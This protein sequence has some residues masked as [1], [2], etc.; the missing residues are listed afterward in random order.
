M[1]LGLTIQQV[2]AATGITKHTLRYYERIGVLPRVTRTMSRHRRYSP[3]DV[4]WV[5]FLRKLQATGMP[6]RMMLEYARLRRQG[7]RTFGERRALL[8]KHKADVEARLAELQSNLEL[9]KWKIG[10]YRELEKGAQV[11]ARRAP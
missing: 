3:E 1:E 8:E 4:R 5:Q 10:K 9:I 7:E 11:H 2:A 6:V